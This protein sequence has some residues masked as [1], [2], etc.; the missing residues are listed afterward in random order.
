[1]KILCVNTRS[2]TDTVFYSANDQLRELV[3]FI[4]RSPGH[5]LVYPRFGTHALPVD[6]APLQ[7]QFGMAIKTFQSICPQTFADSNDQACYEFLMTHSD[8]PWIVHWSGGIDSTSVVTS[9]LRNSNQA[10]RE[11]MFI[12]YNQV[13]VF[14]NPMFFYQHIQPNFQT[15]SV[16]DPRTAD[17]QNFYHVSGCLADQLAGPGTGLEMR[18]INGQALL[19][20]SR[21]IMTKTIRAVWGVNSDWFYDRMIENIQSVE[22]APVE[23]CADFFWWFEFNWVWFD[24]VLREHNSTDPD[25]MKHYIKGK[26]HWFNTPQFHAWAITHAREQ[27]NESFNQPFKIKQEMKNYIYQFDR[28][29]YYKSF[30]TKTHSIS[31]QRQPIW[32]VLDTDLNMYSSCAGIEDSIADHLINP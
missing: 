18:A 17:Y 9:I 29:I 21:D 20:D 13:S 12:S 14:E 22:H 16:H 19:K 27:Y 2:L 1:M 8:R 11:N 24:V 26:I 30:K 15:L 32:Q 23:T 4:G 6:C 5:Q 7:D 25:S 28:N 10:Q 3:D 31:R